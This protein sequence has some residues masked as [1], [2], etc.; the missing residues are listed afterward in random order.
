MK[1]NIRYLN[2]FIMHSSNVRWLLNKKQL[3]KKISQNP[4][5]RELKFLNTFSR[6]WANI[7]EN[8]KPIKIVPQGKQRRRISKEVNVD[9]GHRKL[10]HFRPDG[11][12]SFNPGDAFNRESVEKKA[13]RG[14][15]NRLSTWALLVRAN[16]VWLVRIKLWRLW[17]FHRFII[18]FHSS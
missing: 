10:C 1:K 7:Y 5:S 17:I 12:T 3:T 11:L 4:I 8:G 2:N 6:I 16:T 14:I 13:A 15:S 18:D 9:H